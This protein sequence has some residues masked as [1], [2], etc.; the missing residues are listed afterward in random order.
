MAKTKENIIDIKELVFDDKNFNK[1]TAQGMQMLE[2]SIERNGL[3]R[4]VL[5]DKNNVL[6]GGNGV[7]ETATRLGKR[8]VRIVESDGEELIVVKRT[9]VDINSKKGRELALAD[10]A[11]AAVD[12]DWD[13]EMMRSVQED[14]V[15]INFEDWGLDLPPLDGDEESADTQSS[16]QDDERITVSAESQQPTELKA[17]AALGD[18]WYLGGHRVICSRSVDEAD[19]AMLLDDD[20]VD[21]LLSAD[22][23]N[24]EFKGFFASRMVD[25]A[26][27]YVWADSEHV[28]GALQ[29]FKDNGLALSSVLTWV[30]GETHFSRKDYGS[31]HVMCVY[32]WKMGAARRWYGD[33][34]SV[35]VF[36]YPETD[37]TQLFCMP[38]S[39]VMDLLENSSRQGDVVF[40]PSGT[41]SVL[42]GSHK[43]GRKAYLVADEEQTDK[44][45]YAYL[46][47]CGDEADIRVERNGTEVQYTEIG[48]E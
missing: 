14:C 7:V 9:D 31:K 17:H 41:A 35:D 22:P 38:T 26:P 43:V 27:A 15:D 40:D 21:L 11:T 8:K 5:V 32:G 10:N 30:K 13:E 25:G 47:Y 44:L 12:L 19:Y 46:R 29:A 1:H 23:Q 4:S 2:Q 34:R 16:P 39:L 18:V 33:K 45:I 36:N 37:D 48:K 6:I 28:F 20:S 3:G 42:V 24:S